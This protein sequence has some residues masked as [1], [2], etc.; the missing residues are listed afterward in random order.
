MKL[1]YYLRGLGMGIIFAT[2][3]LSISSVIHNN[4]LSEEIIIKEAKK[5][6]MIMPGET[7]GNKGGLWSNNDTT[8]SVES[9][10]QS[11]TEIDTTAEDDSMA[12]TDSVVETESM[13][14]SESVIENTSSIND[15]ENNTSEV[16]TE[17]ADTTYI[18]IPV[19]P[20]DRARQVA[21]RL[22]ENNLVDSSESFRKYLGESGVAKL[23][24]TG[25]FKIPVGASYDQIV[26][27]LRKR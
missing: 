23:L 12:E 5:L 17:E 24:Q 8:E 4:N 19:Y 7:E 1:K 9:E 18:V 2:L 21:E 14:E 25:E 11:E 6:G 22:Y 3:I 26:E 27:I 15:T 16:T 10:N 20:G 13:P